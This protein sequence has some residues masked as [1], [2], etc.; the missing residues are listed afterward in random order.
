MS[1]TA[2]GLE[3]KRFCRLLAGQRVKR[4]STWK[5]VCQCDCGATKEIAGSSL[6][7]GL[8]R[9][10]GCLAREM[11]GERSPRFKHGR[12]G[13]REYMTWQNMLKRCYVTDHKDFENY[14]G[15]GIAVCQ[16]WRDSF[17]DFLE[18]VGPRP[19]GKTLD[20]RNNDG[21]YEPSNCR[22][23]TPAE[24]AN[25]QRPKRLASH[26]G[27]GHEFTADNTF[28]SKAGHRYCNECR[29]RLKRESYHRLKERAA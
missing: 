11:R 2:F 22:W 19:E 25:N 16:R 1:S 3:G 8:T 9:S 20:R 10:C 29:K 13:T 24:Q 18:D 15:R 21:N 7:Y 23:A 26:C 27:Y 5:Y 4:G 6:S 17:A 28:V 12:T 14:G